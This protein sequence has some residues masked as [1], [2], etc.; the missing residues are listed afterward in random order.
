MILQNY[1]NKIMQKKQRINYKKTN[2]LKF[3]FNRFIREHQFFMAVSKEFK[4]LLKTG[5]RKNTH[6]KN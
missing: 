3:F 5:Y 2:K 6:Q 1:K 4:N